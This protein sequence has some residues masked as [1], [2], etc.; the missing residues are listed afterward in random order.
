[1]KT[2]ALQEQLESEE[3]YKKHL[4]DRLKKINESIEAL[5]QEIKE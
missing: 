4:E 1:M 2:L 5:K 3:L